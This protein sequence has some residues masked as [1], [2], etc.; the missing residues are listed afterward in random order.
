M[1]TG[2]ARP[3][4]LGAPALLGALALLA[5][6]GCG[7]P[8]TDEGGLALELPYVVEGA[9]PFECCTYGTWVAD[10]PIEVRARPERSAEPTFRIGGGDRFEALTGNVV[11]EQP[12]VA[13]ALAPLKLRA[14][15]AGGVLDEMELEVD[16][17]AELALLD[18]LGEGF[19]RVWYR[20]GI[21]MADLGMDD[22]TQVLEPAEWDWWVQ[23]RDAE[24]RTGWFPGDAARVHGND[25]CGGAVPWQEG[26]L[27]AALYGFGRQNG[28]DSS[29]VQQRRVA[30]VDLNGD[31]LDD[32]LVLL[33]G[34][35]W[36]GSGG[37][38]LLVL[39]GERD[40]MRLVSRITLVRGPLV[41]SD[42][43]TAGWRDLIVEVAG[44][45][46]RPGRVALRF[47]GTRYPS[48]PTL[49]ER[50]DPEMPVEG[51]VLLEA[52]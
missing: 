14:P 20:S 15:P 24:G 8:E 23:V 18:P 7:L 41:A 52:P 45:G 11:V 33:T 6:A 21:W 19:Q 9:C 44:G 10:A 47:D 29:A 30:A 39:A 40:G 34:P 13:R 4:L 31:L 43:R 3:Y 48:N 51:Q 32:A 12:G 16:A 28:A 46:A 35:W 50:L 1:N 26:V 22:R 49:Q 38:T 37:C 36:C 27:E 25:A 17:G 42:S 5:A 2:V